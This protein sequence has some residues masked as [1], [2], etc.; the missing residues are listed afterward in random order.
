MKIKFFIINLIAIV[1]SIISCISVSA[2]TT[3]FELEEVSDETKERLISNK[4]INVINEEAGFESISCFDVSENGLVA[5]GVQNG[6]NNFVNIYDNNGSFL[7]GYSVG[8]DGTFGIEFDNDNLII[9]LVRSDIAILI[10]EN[11]NYLEINSIKNNYDNDS[12]WNNV[13][14]AKAK[15]INDSKYQLTNSS[16]F[17][18]FFAPSYSQL[19]KTSSDGTQTIL[20]DVSSEYSVYIIFFIVLGVVLLFSL[21]AIVFH[22][23]KEK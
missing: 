15:E 17:L 3:G 18:K 21:I 4:S 1:L 16:G 23:L 6:I 9:H 22:Y 5:V 2:M 12:Y 10:D 11:G 8:I 19:I 7:Y 20:I 14:F 13:I